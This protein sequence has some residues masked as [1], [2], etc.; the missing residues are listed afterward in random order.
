LASAFFC[1]IVALIIGTILFD[2]AKEK[3][4]DAAG[5][6]KPVVDAMFAELTVLGFIGLLTFVMARTGFLSATSAQVFQTSNSASAEEIKENKDRIPEMFEKLHM[7]LFLV[8]VIF[9]LEVGLLIWSVKWIRKRWE[10][11]EKIKESPEAQSKALKAYDECEN[12]E[13]TNADANLFVEDAGCCQ[14]SNIRPDTYLDYLALRA[15][16]ISP[17]NASNKLVDRDFDFLE[18]LD[19]ALM[20]TLAKLITITALE[21][22]VLLTIILVLFIIHILMDCSIEALQCVVTLVMYIL[23]IMLVLLEAKLMKIKKALV[24]RPKA[25]EFLVNEVQLSAA[26]SK[27]TNATVGTSGTVPETKDSAADEV[28][29]PHQGES[30]PEGPGASSDNGSST[31]A[32]KGAGMDP[33]YGTH[34]NGDAESSPMV[35]SV[36]APADDESTTLL[37]QDAT[38]PAFLSQ[39]QLLHLPW[40]AKCCGIQHFPNKHQSLFWLHEKGPAANLRFLQVVLV[41]LAIYIP[42]FAQTLASFTKEYMWVYVVFV[43]VAILPVPVIFYKTKTVL[44]LQLLVTNVEML[45]DRTIVQESKLKQHSKKVLSLMS[46]INGLRKKAEVF[47]TADVVLSADSQR[48]SLLDNA[49]PLKK[50]EY[51]SLFNVYDK[52]KSNALDAH[53]MASFLESLGIAQAGVMA[54]SLCDKLDL[55]KTGTVDKEEF[56]SY[57]LI[58]DAI[59]KKPENPEEVAA[60]LFALFDENGDGDVSREE[61]KGKLA[62]FGLALNDE[63]IAMLMRELDSDGTGLIDVVD[64]KDMLLKHGL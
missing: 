4:M 3:I 35:A 26:G 50:Q 10:A 22:I 31:G 9:V 53:E 14:N 43:F 25:R 61:M 36:V 18:Y 55:D 28:D 34:D 15:E 51:E 19:L 11:I 17:R 6:L 45:V 12:M 42:V 40:W 63:E 58:T 47:K 23:A 33:G 57:M 62:T 20:K 7:M 52:D 21:W 5:T 16:F 44:Q 37:V 24:C 56:V 60:S 1:C 29:K 64:F 49:D 48:A 27:G 59:N 39:D 41:C 8:M 54:Q 46:T 13:P 32:G 2:A 30:S 38:L